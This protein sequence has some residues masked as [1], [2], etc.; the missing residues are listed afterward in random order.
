MLFAPKDL[1]NFEDYNIGFSINELFPVNVTGIV[2]AIDRL[3]I[4]FSE[5]ELKILTTKILNSP[6]PYSEFD[7]KDQRKHKKELRIEELRSASLLSPTVISYRPFDLRC[8]YY[9]KITECWINSPRY[10]IMKHMISGDNVSLL[11]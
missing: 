11:I 7:I 4:H 3:S 1:S 10:E 6:N 8:M 9:T 2:T 5:D